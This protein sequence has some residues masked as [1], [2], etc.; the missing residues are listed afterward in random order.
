MNESLQNPF[1]ERR[2]GGRFYQ[3]LLIVSTVAF[4]WLAMMVVHEAGHV[5][6]LWFS[7]GQVDYVILHPLKLSYTHPGL[8]PHPLLVAWGGAVWG[9]VLPLVVLA[10]FRRFARRYAYLASFWAGFCLIANGAYLAAD[11]LVRGGDGRELVGYGSPPWL[12]ILIGLPLTGWGLWL[13]NGLGPHFGLGT[14]CGQVDRREALGMTGATT[15]LVTIEVLLA[16]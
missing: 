7:G 8:N 14:G 5:L 15:I 4:S 13:W 10:L 16:C 3:A 6:H 2:F 9:C 1:P 12:L 11:A